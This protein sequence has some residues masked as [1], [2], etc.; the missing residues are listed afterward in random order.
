MKDT[1][2]LTIATSE[3]ITRYGDV[4]SLDVPGEDGYMGIM[5]N[6]IGVVANLIPGIITIRQSSNT[7]PVI[8]NSTGKGFFEF[9]NNSAAI[10]VDQVPV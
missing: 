6:H 5:A 8:L 1:F 7:G 2:E 9:L 10:I 4:V 3:E